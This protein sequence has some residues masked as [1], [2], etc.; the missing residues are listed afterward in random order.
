MVKLKS[1]DFL[2]KEIGGEELEESLLDWSSNEQMIKEYL[3]A[4]RNNKRQWSACAKGRSEVAH[5]RAKPHPQKGTGRA[6]QGSLVSP[7]FRGGGVVFGP[8]PKFNQHVKINQKERKAIINTLIA[9]YAKEGKLN[10][11]KFQSQDAPKTKTLASFLK[12]LQ[13]G[14]KKTLFVAESEG[15]YP[16]Y[17]NFARSLRNLSKARFMNMQNINGYEILNAQSIFI[18]DGALEQLKKLLGRS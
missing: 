18:L 2:G 6:R 3:V 13:L 14:N 9:G 11:L 10:V 7:Q 4:L 1:Y 8:K 15:V 5:T 17:E 12:A 16:K